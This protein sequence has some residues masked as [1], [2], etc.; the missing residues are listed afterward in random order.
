[1]IDLEELE[2]YYYAARY[3]TPGEWEDATDAILDAVPELIK[4]IKFLEKKRVELAEELENNYRFNN[5]CIMNCPHNTE[6][7]EDNADKVID[8]RK[9]TNKGQ[10]EYENA[11]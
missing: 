5:F 8:W 9:L 10:T 11:D 6:C 7:L 3:K 2:Q 1:M 4:H